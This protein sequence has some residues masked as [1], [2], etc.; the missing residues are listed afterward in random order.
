M[1]QFFESLT[2]DHPVDVI[3]HR[4]IMPDGNIRWQ[5]WS[6]RAIFDPSGTI[7]EYQSVGL[8]ITD[9]KQEEQALHENEQRLTSIYNT[10][11]DVIFQLTVES[12][13]QYRF[14]SV[15]SAFS[16]ITGLL[17][18]QVIG[19]KVNEVIPEPSLSMV[20]K[21]YRQAIEEKAIVRWEETSNYPSGEVTGE[22]SIAP[23]FDTA[24]NCTYLI[25]SVHDI[26]DRKKAEE[27]LHET[28]EYLHNLVDYANAP[29]IVWDPEFR[30]TRF[31]HAFEDLTGMTEQ[32]VIG[33]H[34]SILFPASSRETSLEQIKKTLAGE[35]WDVVEIPIL[36]LSGEIRIVLWNSANIVDAS[37]T[38]IS[39]IAQG[40]DITER[41][42]AETNLQRKN[43][44]LNAANEQLAAIEEELR[45]S[46]DELVKS[47]NLL[48][49][50]KAT[51]DSIIN[52]SPIPQ[53]VIDRN[54][55]ITHWNKALAEYSGITAESVIGTTEQWR[56][57]YDTARPC[58]AD[59]L[60]DGKVDKI[61]AWY[62]GKFKKSILIDDAYEATDF[63]P[64]MTGEGKW[65]YFTAGLVRDRDGKVIGAIETLEDI[66]HEKQAQEASALANKKL[67]LLSSITR[68]DILN[69]LTALKGYLELSRRAVH[70]PAKLS[71]FIKKEIKAAE[72]IE[73]QISFTR[74]YQN[75]GVNAPI[76]QNVNA[77][78]SR[79]VAALPMRDVRLELDCTG[80]EVLADQL[81]EKVFYNLI[82]NA[83]RHG[84]EKLSTIR[85][86]CH[87]SDRG[88][89]IVCEDD[90]VGISRNEKE[91]L[92]ER[93]FGK[94][95]GLGLNL[96]REILSITGITIAETGE[97]GKGVRF[98]I[99]VPKGKYRIANVQ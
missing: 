66:T 10:V 85:F 61:S 2:P 55:R 46:F 71:D 92:F 48:E 12:G 83:I 34:L 73:E 39:T 18:G 75:M 74:D 38:I 69:Q 78:I 84:G 59:L 91:H 20:L 23:I 65:L 98:E 21:K 62:E 15:N 50:N 49:E 63:F 82:D 30:I 43:E 17:P 27:A 41:K 26:T 95:T 33:Q 52:E 94:H 37:G 3:E 36:N 88:M 60:L 14:T 28:N 19:R 93:G 47:R 7:T 4:I 90:G 11:G 56:A 57:F 68:H 97:D 24:G 54:H 99:L 8:D 53:Y 80:Y 5:R 76:W 1:R 79:A 6:D 45:T 31:N 70:D 44:E 51:L 9:W 42:Q 13:E 64:R 96:A 22:V 40:Q 32:E 25:G 29:I 81:L 35:R 67:H 89:I 58:L 77:S 86:L 87:E 72:T 16:R